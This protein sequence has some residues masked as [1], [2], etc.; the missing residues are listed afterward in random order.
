MLDAISG[1]WRGALLRRITQAVSPFPYPRRHAG[2]KPKADADICWL[3]DQNNL[4]PLRALRP[5]GR[6]LHATTCLKRCVPGLTGGRCCS[7]ASGP[8]VTISVAQPTESYLDHFRTCS[9]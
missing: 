6:R 8:Q 5:L 4:V 3:Y 2:D 7:P 1:Q 9:G